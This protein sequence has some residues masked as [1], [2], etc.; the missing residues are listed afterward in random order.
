MDLTPVDFGVWLVAS[1]APTLLLFMSG[2]LSGRSVTLRPSA[3]LICGA[4][5]LG[6]MLLARA[7]GWPA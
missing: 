2:F 1:T 6:V 4:F 7:V 5:G 3:L